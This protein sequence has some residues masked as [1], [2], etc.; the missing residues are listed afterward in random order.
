M[1]L[2]LAEARLTVGEKLDDRPFRA[3]LDELVEVDEAPAHASGNL[4][5]K[6]RLPRAHEPHER[7]VLVRHGHALVSDTALE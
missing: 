2:E 6:R 1:R 7:E 3:G 5:A 4:R